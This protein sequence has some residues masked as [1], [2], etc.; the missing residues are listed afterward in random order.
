[1][2]ESQVTELIRLTASLDAKMSALQL[3]IAEMKKSQ[4][5]L[6]TKAND[7]KSRL[8]TIWAE[9]NQIKENCKKV[10]DMAKDTP[11]RPIWQAI[12]HPT[13]PIVITGVLGLIILLVLKS[14]GLTF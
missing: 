3:D 9:H 1:M 6:F 13:V 5:A 11:S 14:M 7:N 12:L 10:N 8:D 4:E 2:T